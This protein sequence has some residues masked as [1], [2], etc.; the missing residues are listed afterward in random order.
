MAIGFLGSA[1]TSKSTT[2]NTTTNTTSVDS[3]NRSF[4]KSSVLDNV[5]NVMVQLGAGAPESTLERYLPAVG[6][7]LLILY[8]VK[9]R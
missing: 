7:G 9:N 2:Y 6:V 8:A 4:S 1:S 5:G 3:Y